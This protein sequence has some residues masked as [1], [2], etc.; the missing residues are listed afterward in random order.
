MAL[1]ALATAIIGMAAP[2]VIGAIGQRNNWDPK[3]T[4]F[5]SLAAGFGAGAA[6]A[7]VFSGGASSFG[8]LAGGANAIPSSVTSATNSLASGASATPSAFRAAES[9]GLLNPL[10]AAS[11]ITAPAGTAGN[12]AY[13]TSGLTPRNV[14]SRWDG[15]GN[16]MDTQGLGINYGNLPSPTDP[17]S[18]WDKLKGYA[19]SP[20]G[21]KYITAAAGQ[22][23]DGM[24]AQKPAPR[25]SGGGGGGGGGGP[26]APAY[27][28][29]GGSGQ[30]QVV[31]NFPQSGANPQLVN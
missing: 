27:P 31:W 5:L 23:M 13:S 8:S 11:K 9:F 16:P 3:L 12:I 10:D 2:K 24:F 30:K 22:F 19:T 26:R 14:P 18:T 6:G 4:S 25:S 17:P 21:Q 28:G 20:D 29:G 15:W 1:P 7:G